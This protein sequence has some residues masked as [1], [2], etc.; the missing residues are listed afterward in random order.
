MR[1]ATASLNIALS[2]QKW[3]NLH[4]CSQELR[5]R[6]CMSRGTQGMSSTTEA[7]SLSSKIFIQL[8]PM[9]HIGGLSEVDSRL[10][11]KLQLPFLVS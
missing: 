5:V 11:G 2:L 8:S 9:Q 4:G 6:R 1:L 10:A 7:W 3:I